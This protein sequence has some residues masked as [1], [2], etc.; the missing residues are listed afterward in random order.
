MSSL[1]Y[2]IVGGVLG[3]IVAFLNSLN[4]SNNKIYILNHTTEQISWGV[5]WKAIP[6]NAVIGVAGSISVIGFLEWINKLN[7]QPTDVYSDLKI[8]GVSVVAGFAAR[9][10]MPK[11]AEKL[12]DRVFDAIKE[13]E[14]KINEISKENETISKL[15]KINS[16]LDT[17]Y[18]ALSG[19]RRFL[20]TDKQKVIDGLKENLSYYEHHRHTIIALGRV[21]DELMQDLDGAIK[22]T[23]DF[24][25]NVKKHS[26]YTKVVSTVDYA[27]VLY[28][29]ACFESLKAKQEKR[30]NNLTESKKYEDLAIEH[31]KESI[32]LRPINK[33]DAKI[34]I[35]PNREEGKEGDLQFLLDQGRVD[36][37]C[38]FT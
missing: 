11:I 9:A 5:F 6:I 12:G 36:T 33:E 26:D 23:T 30:S 22:V 25:K 10:I 35:S 34:D 3:G 8:F 16:N 1:L 29:L 32:E 14:H 37:E 27:D 7:I 17:A 31:L 13:N 18:E 15:Q 21:Y 38:N 2:V 24:I 28:N 20:V 4:I 19:Q